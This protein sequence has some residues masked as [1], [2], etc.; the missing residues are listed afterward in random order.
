[1][2][3]SAGSDFSALRRFS[4]SDMS[5][6]YRLTFSEPLTLLRGFIC[7]MKVLD[8]L[9]YPY[10]CTIRI[11]TQQEWYTTEPF[12]RYIYISHLSDL[13]RL[14][15]IIGSLKNC[16]LDNSPSILNP[17]CSKALIIFGIYKYTALL[18]KFKYFTVISL[19]L[20]N[21]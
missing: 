8:Q 3:R 21:F 16:G 2:Q 19:V 20:L 7:L 13:I 12:N 4:I 6:L 5:V 17:I 9:K 15:H 1:M 18:V 14:N 11:F 10:R